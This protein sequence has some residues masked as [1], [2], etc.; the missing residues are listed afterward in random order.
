MAYHGAHVAAAAAAERRRKLEE[1]EEEK[2]TKYNVDEIEKWE[3]KIVRSDSGAFRKPEVLQVVLEEEAQAGWEMVEKFDNRRIRF[4]RPIE[5]RKQ[6]EMLPEYFD[7]YRTHYGNSS[8]RLVFALALGF[9][10]LGILVFVYTSAGGSIPES[11]IA[12]TIP[13]IAIIVGLLSVFVVVRRSG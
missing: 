4:R 2:M 3:F 8:R 9:F 11:P 1:A 13:I 12:L 6:D 7:P 10:M 5:A